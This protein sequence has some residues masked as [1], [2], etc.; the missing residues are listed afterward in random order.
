MQQPLGCFH[1]SPAAAVLL[2]VTVVRIHPIRIPVNA[3]GSPI[4][5]SFVLRRGHPM[6]DKM[7]S[8]R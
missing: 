6:S 2:P 5:A 8:A 7:H 4:Q 3:F 1:R